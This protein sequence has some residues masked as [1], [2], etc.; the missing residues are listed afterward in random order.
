MPK[1]KLLYSTAHISN[2]N[3]TGK[4]DRIKVMWL[5]VCCPHCL[6]GWHVDFNYTFSE[7]RGQ[8]EREDPCGAFVLYW[9]TEETYWMN[10]DLK[11][12]F[13]DLLRNTHTLFGQCDQYFFFYLYEYFKLISF[14]RKAVKTICLPCQFNHLLTGRVLSTTPAS[15]QTNQLTK[16]MMWIHL[17]QCS[18]LCNIQ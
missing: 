12:V 17:E 8:A 14:Q 7:R 6:T 16:N 10:S 4:Q 1:N 5:S 13:W 15:S 18:P 9:L 3:L 11:L 2:M